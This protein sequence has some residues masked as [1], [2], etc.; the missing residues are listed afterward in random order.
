MTNQP[1]NHVSHSGHAVNLN[2]PWSLP[3]ANGDDILQSER[4]ISWFDINVIETRPFETD[5][6]TAMRFKESFSKIKIEIMKEIYGERST[7]KKERVVTWIMPFEKALDTFLENMGEWYFDVSDIPSKNNQT[8]IQFLMKHLII[9]IFGEDIGYDTVRI[10][11]INDHEDFDD[12]EDIVHKLSMK[13]V[14]RMVVYLIVSKTLNDVDRRNKM[15]A[16]LNEEIKDIIDDRPCSTGC[17]NRLLN[18]LAR[19]P[20]EFPYAIVTIEENSEM[21]NLVCQFK[22]KFQGQAL[23]NNLRA[24]FENRGFDKRKIGIWLKHLEEEI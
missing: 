11:D 15:F 21:S 23:V 6:E 18:T 7:G 14:F 8:K 12:Y 4:P 17:I 16:S 9:L 1:Q 13:D 20:D 24:E 10:D 22:K 5:C 3:G 2:L 19:Y